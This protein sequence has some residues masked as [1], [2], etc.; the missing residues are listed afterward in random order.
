MRENK[1]SQTL[2][3]QIKQINWLVYLLT[4]RS[5]GKKSQGK[6]IHY[7]SQKED[8]SPVTKQDNNDQ[9]FGKIALVQSQNQPN[10]EDYAFPEMF[11]ISDT[12]ILSDVQTM[13]DSTMFLISWFRT[14][15]S[16][17]QLIKRWC[18]PF[19]VFPKHLYVR[20]PK[21]LS[22]I[23]EGSPPLE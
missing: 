4:I 1:K 23:P 5:G 21:F 17:K 18:V 7:F 14:F 16:G 15:F 22:L 8:T 2:D 3:W 19:L 10:S 12:G 11:L 9:T 20:C 6:K 13:P